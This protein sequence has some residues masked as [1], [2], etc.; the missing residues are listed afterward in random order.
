MKKLF[1]TLP[2]VMI[3]ISLY[4]QKVGINTTSPLETLD[5]RGTGYFSGKLG[6]GVTSPQYPLSFS[7]THGDKISFQGS[8]GPHYG[9]GIQ[10]QLLQV[11]TA[12][13]TDDIAFGYGS[14]TSFTETMRIKGNGYMGIGTNSPVT[15]LHVK[16]S[17]SNPVIFDGGS[18][19]WVTLAEN[20]V[21]RGYI[22]SYAGN[23]ADVELGTYGGT[24][25]SVH[26][27]TNNYPR[28]TVVNNGNVGIGTSSPAQKLHVVGNICA[29]GTIGSCSD[30][31]YKQN[32][33]PLAHSLVAI[34]SLHGISYNWKKN[35]FPQMQFDNE[36][37]IGF[38]AQEVEKLFP[39]I[40]MTD[41][42]GYKSVDYGRL[43]PILVEAVKEQQKQINAQ[44]EQIN[45]LKKMM[46]ELL[47][48][49]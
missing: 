33:S 29:T 7:S 37:Q 30:I 8:S 18:S 15:T 48:K 47:S 42:N 5:V 14:S 9:L 10:N 12:A 17:L 31:R 25:G 2:I 19:M 16:T 27:T 3:S 13:N 41:A 43:T 22:G 24:T 32:I 45:E 20:G 34:L 11:H 6:L 28:L 4:S 39:E 49:Q 44:Q 1:S 38:S 36:R 46:E 35:E 26:L 23:A 21:N 40:V